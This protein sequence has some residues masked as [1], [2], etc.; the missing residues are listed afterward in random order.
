LKRLQTR[1]QALLLSAEREETAMRTQRFQACAAG[2]LSMCPTQGIDD[3]GSSGS[4]GHSGTAQQ[5]PEGSD[6]VAGL[7]G[8]ASRNSA[9]ENVLAISCW[10]NRLK[11]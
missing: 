11:R 1:M 10:D 3:S 4:G 6:A 2:D 5:Q 7:S 8:V 9:M